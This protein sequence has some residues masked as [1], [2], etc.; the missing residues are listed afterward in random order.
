MWILF[1]SVEG[2]SDFSPQAPGSAGVFAELDR[3]GSVFSRFLSG[4]LGLYSG[5][6]IEE[7]AS[8]TQ[9]LQGTL[10]NKD[11]YGRVIA[12]A[13]HDP[14]D[15]GQMPT[16]KPDHTDPDARLVRAIGLGSAT[17][18]VI[19][20]V[21]GSA[22]FLTTG[23]M[24]QQMP[25]AALLLLAWSVGGLLALSGGLTCAELGAMY[26]HSGGWY[27][28]LR[29]AYGP[30]WG[31]LFGWAG[32][33]VMLTGS[34][35]AV[36]VGFA[37]YFSYFFPSLATSR[38]LLSLPL[39]WGTLHVSAG[40]V[41]AASS[42]AV[43]GAINYLGVRLGNAVQALL[44]AAKVSLLAL[45]PA[46]ALVLHPVHPHLRPVASHVP[47]AATSFGV[48]MIAV[49]W[50]YSGWDWMCF[51]AGEIEQP[52][53]NVP[54]AL[55]L[56][57]AALTVLYV[58]T[59]LGYLYSLSIGDMMGVLRIAERSVTAMIGAGGAA[60]VAAA[61][62]I[63]T[64]GCNAAGIIPTSR[65]CFAMSSD[66]LFLKSAAA[67]HPRFHTPHVAVVLT[68]LWAAILALTGTYEQLYTY[69]VFTAL[70]FNVAG[71]VAVFRLRRTQPDRPR[72][73]R[74]WGYPFVPALFVL[75]TA[76][77]VVST[78]VQRPVESITGLG[79]LAL[80]LPAY[81]YWSKRREEIPR[82]L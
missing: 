7:A 49:M 20:N 73:Y 27:V 79:L 69:V 5:V 31:F 74:V 56:G 12:Q 28:Y 3:F 45:I 8:R 44:T 81:R 48:A 77:L 34:L 26:P 30:I 25:S 17:L 1:R 22:I 71:G 50:A 21:L 57:A 76:T 46:M 40:Q 4:L 62:M 39:H 80:G 15:R 16:L 37:E 55:I 43:L 19:G 58:A 32:I 13:V 36:A 10:N 64:L 67:V 38:I 75:S 60:F 42:L 11:V 6:E 82:G 53:R 61:V 65:V 70:L 41:V 33:L 35:A 23:K 9:R 14:R 66:G 78:L 2:I 72:P 24:A 47:H 59:N 29:E 52:K 18:L 51:A 63:S 68:C 54:R